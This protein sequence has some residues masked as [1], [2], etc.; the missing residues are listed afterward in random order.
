MQQ[1]EAKKKVFTAGQLADVYFTKN[2]LGH[3]K[4]P[5]IVRSSIERDIKPNIGKIPVNEVKPLHISK[6]LESIVDRGAPT[7]AIDVLHWTK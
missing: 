7:V 5:N 2:I 6:M 4:H 1:I 3:W